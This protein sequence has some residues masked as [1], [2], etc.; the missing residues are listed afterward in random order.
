MDN[1]YEYNDEN[2]MEVKNG[3]WINSNGYILFYEKEKRKLFFNDDE[4]VVCT[5]D[6]KKD[7]HTDNLK[8]AILHML[9]SGCQ[10]INTIS[11]R[12]YENESENEIAKRLVVG[13]IIN[14]EIKEFYQLCNCDSDI[15]FLNNIIKY[16]ELDEPNNGKFDIQIYY[17]NTAIK[18]KRIREKEGYEIKSVITVKKNQLEE[19]QFYFYKW[20]IDDC[21]R[22]DEMVRMVIYQNIEIDDIRNLSVKFIKCLN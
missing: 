6:F 2:V 13:E 8:E 22:N 9:K 1:W 14:E 20:D 4:A 5:N 17:W 18:S 16:L 10:L 21:K 11:S 3:E 15:D 19:D 7:I 12:T